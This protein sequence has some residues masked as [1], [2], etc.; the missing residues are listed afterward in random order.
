M[1]DQSP[2]LFKFNKEIAISPA[3]RYS[4]K[5][6]LLKKILIRFFLKKGILVESLTVLESKENVLINVNF[7]LTTAR[8]KLAKVG[9][10]SLK[11]LATS[12]SLLLRGDSIRVGKCL[13]CLKSYLLSSGFKG[14]VSLKFKRLNV[15]SLLLANDYIKMPEGNFEERSSK[16]VSTEDILPLNKHYT[17]LSLIATTKNKLL[18]D[19]DFKTLRK[20]KSHEVFLGNPHILK[21]Q[22]RNSKILKSGNFARHLKPF[23]SRTLPRSLYKDFCM[24]TFLFVFSSFKSSWFIFLFSKIFIRLKK[25]R[26][27]R[28][29]LFALKRL[30]SKT[31]FFSNRRG[32]DNILGFSFSCCGKIGGKLRAK[33]FKFS[34]G[35]MPTQSFN[36]NIK[37]FKVSSTHRRLGVY[38]F[39]VNF[40]IV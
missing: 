22:E 39:I 26:S 2:L 28:Y 31:F 7:L 35:I 21:L 13:E 10:R 18:S 14:I 11:R 12:S 15:I 30:L 25:K 36:N 1:L 5:N 32:V 34:H 38:S 19:N 24:L 16:R 9:T 40:N 4:Y 3:T 8:Q 29:L 20:K 17:F 6:L 27:Q 37:S 23:Y 33:T